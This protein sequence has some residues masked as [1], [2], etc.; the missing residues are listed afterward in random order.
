M[1][2]IA[3]GKKDGSQEI[4]KKKK[5][6]LT[7]RT[8]VKWNKPMPGKVITDLACRVVLRCGKFAFGKTRLGHVINKTS[9]KKSLDFIL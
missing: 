2:K 6:K 4:N 3:F 1:H 5:Q 8:S 9:K 7:A